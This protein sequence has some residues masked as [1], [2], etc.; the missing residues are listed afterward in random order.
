VSVKLLKLLFIIKNNF[1]RPKLNKEVLVGLECPGITEDVTMIVVGRNGIVYHKHFE[2]L[3]QHTI[4][5]SFTAN[6]KMLPEAKVVF[7]AIKN[8]KIIHGSATVRFDMLSENFV[9]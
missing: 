3:Q 8:G 5:T 1:F 6:Q 7:Y 2:K 9:S 4:Q